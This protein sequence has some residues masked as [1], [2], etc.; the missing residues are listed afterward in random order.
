MKAEYIAG[1]LH[2]LQEQEF[3]LEAFWG[4]AGG[5]FCP[6][7]CG[8][9]C[10]GGEGQAVEGGPL[11]SF[12]SAPLVL[13]GPRGREPP[14]TCSC[15][16]VPSL[17]WLTA[18]SCWPPSCRPRTAGPREGSRVPSGHFPPRPG[19]LGMQLLPLQPWFLMDRKA[20][21]QGA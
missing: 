21:P 11:A 17:H 14:R 5:G 19:S 12:A 10:W 1:H 6:G 20:D 8:H 9:A 16:I 7:S 18:A 4:R 15:P 3:I 2:L 13:V